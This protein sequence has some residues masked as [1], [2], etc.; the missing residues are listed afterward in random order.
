MNPDTVGAGADGLAGH[1]FLACERARRSGPLARRS[2]FTL[3]DLP[4]T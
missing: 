4:L 1:E 2:D 3:R